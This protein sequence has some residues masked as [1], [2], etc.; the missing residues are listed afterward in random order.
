MKH[1][2]SKIKTN[3]ANVGR[4]GF[5]A[6]ELKESLTT[7]IRTY[8]AFFIRKLAGSKGNS[9]ISLV[10]MQRKQ[11]EVNKYR[12]ALGLPRIRLYQDLQTWM[13]RKRNAQKIKE[14][15]NLED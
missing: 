4:L 6:V 1:T 15:Y 3:F 8:K 12:R 14:K 11:G 9:P 5:H 7:D 13:K 10:S 2:R